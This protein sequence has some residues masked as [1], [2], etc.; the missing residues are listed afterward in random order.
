MIQD[1][2]RRMST[3]NSNQKIPYYFTAI[4]LVLDTNERTIE[5]I[6]AG[7]L[8]GYAL[9]DG[10]TTVELKSNTTAVGFFDDIR[11]KKNIIHYS[12]SVQLILCTDGVHEAIDKYGETGIDLIKKAA[13]CRL[14][15][16]KTSEP[17]DLITSKDHQKGATDDM[18]VV[19]IQAD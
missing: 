18:C 3:L 19:L 7:H 5:Y 4:Y 8:D 10:T 16:A 12:N 1:L 15:D 13:S 9:I 14:A 17:I 11:T 2:N 6:N